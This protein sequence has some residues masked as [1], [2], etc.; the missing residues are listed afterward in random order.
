MI[1]IS[2]EQTTGFP[3][4]ED[5]S[6]AFGPANVQWDTVDANAH[7]CLLYTSDAADE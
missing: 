2:P 4:G 7:H 1:I 6:G 3:L 5:A